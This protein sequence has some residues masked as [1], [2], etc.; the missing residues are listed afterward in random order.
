MP[1]CILFRINTLGTFIVA[2]ILQK[3]HGKKIPFKNT[4]LK[5]CFT[6][7]QKAHADIIEVNF[8]CRPGQ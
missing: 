6:M 4:T 2:I 8:V 1:T 7:H 3:R 5:T